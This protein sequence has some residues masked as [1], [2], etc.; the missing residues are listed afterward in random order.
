VTL[1]A[2]GSAVTLTAEEAIA[3]E[4]ARMLAVGRILPASTYVRAIEALG[5]NGIGK[6]G[7]LLG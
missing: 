3:H 2:G 6:L 1:S 4:V 5:R 7:F